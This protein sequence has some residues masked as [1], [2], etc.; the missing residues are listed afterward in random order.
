[1]ISFEDGIFWKSIFNADHP[2]LTVCI[3]CGIDSVLRINLFPRKIH[4]WNLVEY[5]Y[6]GTREK[7]SVSKRMF[8]HSSPYPTWGSAIAE[9]LQWGYGQPAAA[10]VLG[11]ELFPWSSELL[12]LGSAFNRIIVKLHS[13][14]RLKICSHSL[15]K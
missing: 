3:V 4:I 15:L 5:A 1:M 2:L 12:H 7:V 8:L 10:L 9:P 13:V 11:L 14:F 6:M